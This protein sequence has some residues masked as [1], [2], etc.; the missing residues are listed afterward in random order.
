M[1][2]FKLGSFIYLYMFLRF[3]FIYFRER[4]KER[5]VCERGE[6]Q[7]ERGRERSTFL[8]EHGAPYRTNPTTLRLWSEAE[9]R[10][11]RLNP[12]SHPGAPQL[13][14]FKRHQ[15]ITGLNF[16]DPCCHT[17]FLTWR[18]SRTWLLPSRISVLL[19]G[20]QRYLYFCKCENPSISFSFFKKKSCI[21]HESVRA[22]VWAQMWGAEADGGERMPSRLCAERAER[23][24]LHGWGSISPPWDRDLSQSQEW[25][26]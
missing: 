15:A 10:S 7:G 18:G 4:E 13:G 25:D 11:L 17:S 6:G 9:I 16:N 24:A 1:I 26:A 14:G 22:R 3:I 12:L 5:A 8:T 23:R 2:L 19:L 20:K 21:E